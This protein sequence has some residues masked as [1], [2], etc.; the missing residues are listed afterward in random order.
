[1]ALADSNMKFYVR[2]GRE[3]EDSHRLNRL[4][5]AAM[6]EYRKWAWSVRKL[7]V[8]SGV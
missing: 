5:S 6:E 8:L 3:N 4:A 2:Y 1:M 7:V